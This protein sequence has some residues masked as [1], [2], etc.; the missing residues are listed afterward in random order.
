MR[1]QVLRKLQLLRLRLE[2][3]GPEQFGVRAVKSY[4]R[5]V[6]DRFR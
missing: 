6:L 4:Y 5:R 2:A 3:H 1:T